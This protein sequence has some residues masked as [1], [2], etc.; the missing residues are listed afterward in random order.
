MDSCRGLHAFQS[1]FSRAASTVIMPTAPSNSRVV[2]DRARRQRSQHDCWQL[3]RRSEKE[4]GGRDS[5]ACRVRGVANVQALQRWIQFRNQ[6]FRRF[7]VEGFG[8]EPRE[9]WRR[10][11][12]RDSVRWTQTMNVAWYRL[13]SGEQVLPGAAE[14]GLR[15]PLSRLGS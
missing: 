3:D 4:I 9:E 2:V 6:P 8:H 13:F 12:A 1:H 5:G 14:R 10:R 11:V 15:G 7:L